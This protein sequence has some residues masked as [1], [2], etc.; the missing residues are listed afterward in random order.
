MLTCDFRWQENWLPNFQRANGFVGI[1]AQSQRKID[2]Q[3]AG[4]KGSKSE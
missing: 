1:A 4:V 2:I 3:A